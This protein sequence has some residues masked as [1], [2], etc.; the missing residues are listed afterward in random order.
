MSNMMGPGASNKAAAMKLKGIS[1][2]AHRPSNLSDRA[3]LLNNEEPLQTPTQT[4]S[5]EQ[6]KSNVPPG[7]M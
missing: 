1:G 3:G 2:H 4:N 6:R 7:G 5:H